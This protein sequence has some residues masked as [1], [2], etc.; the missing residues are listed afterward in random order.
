M[1]RLQKAMVE[2]LRTDAGVAAL[3]GERIYDG[4]PQRSSKPF[5]SIGSKTEVTANVFG[6]DGWENTITTHVF[7]GA[8]PDGT[9]LTQSDDPLLRIVEAMHG[10]FKEPLVIEG[11]DTA[12]LRPEFSTTLEEEGGKVRHAPVRYRILTFEAA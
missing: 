7:T 11:H 10:A 1:R 3:I 6:T 12:F 2:R 8:Y 5:I 4:L 9:T